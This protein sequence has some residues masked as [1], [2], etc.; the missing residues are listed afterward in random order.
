[1]PAALVIASLLARQMA[2]GHALWT[3]H[4][5]TAPADERRVARAHWLAGSG[6][7]ELAT[8]RSGRVVVAVAGMAAAFVSRLTDD[9]LLPWLSFLLVAFVGWCLVCSAGHAPHHAA[10]VTWRTVVLWAS[11]NPP[12]P[13]GRTLLEPYTYQ[14][15]EP[16][17]LL[18]DRVFALRLAVVA[19]SLAVTATVSTSALP[20]PDAGTDFVR[21]VSDLVIDGVRHILV[22]TLLPFL[23]FF[24]TL[25]VIYGTSLTDYHGRFAASSVARAKR[26]SPT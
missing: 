18:A 2:T 3:T 24:T 21:A 13:S 16:W 22:L 5:L 10:A 12:L 4:V 8:I 14:M 26:R 25:F 11:Y 15:P 1:V 6:T 7:A 23:L 19:L 17:L 20:A 9:G